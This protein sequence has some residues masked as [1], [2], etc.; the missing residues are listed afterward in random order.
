MTT[1][2]ARRSH[3]DIDC[4]TVMDSH[5]TEIFSAAADRF[6]W[7][8]QLLEEYYQLQSPPHPDSDLANARQFF[9]NTL[10]QAKESLDL[11]FHGEITDEELAD[12]TYMLESASS[13]HTA[14]S[15]FLSHD[16]YCISEIFRNV[17]QAVQDELVTLHT[18]VENVSAHLTG[19]VDFDDC[20]SCIAEGQ[21]CF[22]TLIEQ[23]ARLDLAILSANAISE[24]DMG[25][26]TEK[27]RLLRIVQAQ[28]ERT[29]EDRDMIEGLISFRGSTSQDGYESDVSMEEGEW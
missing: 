17:C 22:Q 12:L 13:L 20:V 7:I 16:E 18:W 8:E 29:L 15:R 11:L 1:Q 26:N 19:Q 2:A 10:R 28:A 5:Y 21:T 6:K 24:A 25:D 3:L 9:H 27:H 4:D 14:R 23:A